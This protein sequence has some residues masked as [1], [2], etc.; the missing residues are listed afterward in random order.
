MQCFEHGD[1][2]LPGPD[3]LGCAD[4]AVAVGV[5][6]HPGQSGRIGVVPVHLA[7][8]VLDVDR[9]LRDLV[10]LDHR[11]QQASGEGT[12]CLQGAAGACRNRP[13]RLQVLGPLVT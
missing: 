10:L 12:R 1:R 4:G 2:R 5:G 6:S 13:R 7:G 3:L 8:A 9:V 11:P